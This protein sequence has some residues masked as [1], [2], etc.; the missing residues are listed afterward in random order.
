MKQVFTAI[1]CVVL[2]T[3]MPTLLLAKGDTV[4]ITLESAGL[5]GPIEITDPGV[6]QFNIW[7]G[8]GTSTFDGS[9]G[10]IIDWT[11]RLDSPPAGLHHYKLSFYEGC[12]PRTESAC[13]TAV[14]SLAYVVFYDYDPSTQ[15]GFVY[16]PGGHDEFARLNM[17][18]IYR[19]DGFNGHWFRASKA[20]DTFVAPIIGHHAEHAAAR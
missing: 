2:T 18:T 3:A 11:S 19:G 17:A 20:W 16:L 4:K 6:R 14:P 13:H 7:S 12:D 1:L 10:F 9:Q 5:V 15:A 8:P